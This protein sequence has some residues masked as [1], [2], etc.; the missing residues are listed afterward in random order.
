MRFPRVVAFTVCLVVAAALWGGVAVSAADAPV[1]IAVVDLAKLDDSP[2][3]KQYNEQFEALRKSLDDILGIRIQN[4]LLNEDEIKSLI[5]LKTK[6]K[7]TDAEQTKLKALE[8]ESKK[9]NDELATLK[10]TKDLTDAQK[11]RQAEL[12]QIEKKSRETGENLRKEYESQL[13]KKYSELM[14]Q[15]RVDTK[16]AASKVAAEKGYTHVLAS[17]AVLFGG[18]DITDLMIIKLDRKAQ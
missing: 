16:E 5:D 14:A 11:T 9:R 10:Q 3:L 2:R 4:L 15:F 6:D 17:D 8:D 1:K 18:T 13:N 12:Q 7:P